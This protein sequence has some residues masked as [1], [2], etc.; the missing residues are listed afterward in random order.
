MLGRLGKL[1]RSRVGND[2]GERLVDALVSCALLVSDDGTVERASPSAVVLLRLPSATPE[3]LSLG[4]VLPGIRHPGEVSLGTPVETVAARADGTTFPASAV[5]SAL[6]DS[7]HGR[8]LVVLTDDAGVREAERRA[9][10]A[11]EMLAT[12]FEA[13]TD[14]M[15]VRDLEGRYIAANAAASRLI[16][17]P[18]S[19]VVGRHMLEVGQEGAEEMLARDAE[20]F[21][22]AKPAVFMRQMLVEGEMAWFEVSRYPLRT[23]GGAI[24]GVVVVMRDITADR[25]TSEGLARA[26]ETAERASA[27]RARFLAAASH[28]LRQP[29]QAISLV[30]AV[31]EREPMTPRGREALDQMVRGV[32]ALRNL[33][34]A[35][36]D[37]HQLEGGGASAQVET[38]ALDGLLREVEAA[39]RPPAEAKGLA[40]TIHETGAHVASDRARL[41]QMLLNLVQNAVRYTDA[42]GV[43]LSASVTPAGTLRLRVEDTGIGI[44]R[45]HLSRIW[46]EFYQ[47]GNQERDRSRGLGLGLSI[48]SRLSRL[49][50]HP[51]AVETE[52]GRGSVFS[53][54]V[55]LVRA[56]AAP[57]E[58]EAERPAASVPGRPLVVLVD[59][60][61]LV[62]MALSSYLDGKGFRVAAAETEEA[63]VAALDPADP[64]A[65]IV[66][67][68]R[69]RAGRTGIGAVEAVRGHIG[70]HLPGLLLTGEDSGAIETEA[71]RLG[72]ALLRKP[73]SG[74]ALSDALSRAIGREA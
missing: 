64:P 37:I 17:L 62:L 24:R 29:V 71:E 34:G 47:V 36:L 18:Q 40:F 13:V 70:Q 31:L 16:G 60:D 7:A 32:D 51:V 28:D 12:V 11:S 23:E 46:D 5:R 25:R 57:A 63:A 1:V 9:R 33:L 52:H 35:L 19:E 27:E 4:D 66:A 41:G 42:G 65:A 55:P 69:L 73:V 43:T 59:D 30:A 44:P 3:G 45:E 15:V 58:P 68:Y 53:V 10:E 74:A 38:F 14:S 67:D 50:G 61:Q 48:V 2:A 22:T 6:P 72:L 21:R 54:E 56:D 8:H 20:V 26:K 49:L 39:A